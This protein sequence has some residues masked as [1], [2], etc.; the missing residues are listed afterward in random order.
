M[1]FGR[2]EC[3]FRG[4]FFFT[5]KFFFDRPSNHSLI[6]WRS[7]V[8]SFSELPVFLVSD[9]GGDSRGRRR[10]DRV[11]GAGDAGA[12]QAEAASGE[13]RG[14]GQAGHDEAPLRHPRPIGRD[15]TSGEVASMARTRS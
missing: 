1:I 4:I 2:S 14:Q 13:K 7:Q 15:E 6:E 12:S 3:G 8:S 11:L 9:V 5:G 10:L